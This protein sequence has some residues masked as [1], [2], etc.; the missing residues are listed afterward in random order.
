MGS[1]RGQKSIQVTV[2]AFRDAQLLDIAGPLEVFECANRWLVE[3]RRRR[4]PFYRLE[5]LSDRSGVLATSGVLKS[6]PRDHAERLPRALRSTEVLITQ[7]ARMNTIGIVLYDGVDALDAIG[8][9]ESFRKARRSDAAIDAIFLAPDGATSIVSSDGFPFARWESLE[10]TSVDWLLVPGGNW[11]R[12]GPR[13]AWAEIQKGALPAFLR[14]R[15]ARG[16]QMASVCTGAMILSAAGVTA[17]RTVTTHTVARAA[18]R[19]EGA[20]V[21]D[22]RV[23]DDGDLVSSAGVT[24]GIDLALWL[25]ERLT[26]AD[27]A[28]MVTATLEWDRNA[29]VFRGPNAT[30][31]VKP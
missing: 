1:R 20:E 25:I 14:E 3:H 27:V 18:L 30:K 19:A 29:E 23:V 16:Q 12:R 11:A 24:A 9:W 4:T 22:A 21:I 10:A 15:R 8:P 31:K 2:V 26:S 7:G 17:G 5:L 13:G 6:S 28:A